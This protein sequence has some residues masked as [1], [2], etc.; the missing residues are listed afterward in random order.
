[1]A[2]SLPLELLLEIAKLLRIDGGSLVPCTH[3]CRYWR[4]A[5][6]PLVYANL[7]VY[8]D[9]YHKEKGPRGI[10]LTHFQ[11]LTS[12]SRAIRRNWI[13]TLEFDVII[14]C[15]L[16]DWTTRQSENYSTNNQV[17][18]G[19]DIAFQAAIFDL[20]RT[21]HSWNQRCR[22]SLHLGRRVSR[23]NKWP[24]WSQRPYTSLPLV[25]I[26]LSITPVDTL[27]SQIG[28]NPL[29]TIIIRSGL[30]QCRLSSNAVQP[31][32]NWSRISMNGSV[33][34]I[35]SIYKDVEH[36]CLPCEAISLAA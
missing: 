6:E 14:P 16:L 13:R 29:G 18:Q 31:S 20:F 7:A 12:G 30:G 33:R 22:L 17:R 28:T 21:L 19:N 4:A 23:D 32:L 10:S 15:K 27:L 24:I 34:I 25:H 3:V 8:S 2:A 11:K 36:H 1:M 26:I 9:Y 35:Y 5:F